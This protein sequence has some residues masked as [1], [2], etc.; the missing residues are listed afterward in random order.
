LISVG[1]CVGAIHQVIG[2]GGG[3][4]AVH[5]MFMRAGDGG[6]GGLY[7]GIVGGDPGGLSRSIHSIV[8]G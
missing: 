6:H 2:D 3:F 7:G 1:G 4:A 8:H 5:G